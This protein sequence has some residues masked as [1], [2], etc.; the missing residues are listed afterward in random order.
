MG[1]RLA[2]QALTAGQELRCG[3]DHAGFS[4]TGRK[5]SMGGA[6]ALEAS[7]N[8][9][10]DA[11]AHLP[12]NRQLKPGYLCP[13]YLDPSFTTENT[14]RPPIFAQQGM[15]LGPNN[16]FVVGVASDVAMFCDR[17]R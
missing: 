1:R 14:T 12:I 6:K 9:A 3:V 11:A 4:R 5:R 16:S 17:P 15:L 2:E 8:L 7:L 10:I 13:A